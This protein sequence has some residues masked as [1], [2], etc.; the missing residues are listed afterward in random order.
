MYA[1][2]SNISKGKPVMIAE[3]GWPN[4]GDNSNKA[5]P[6]D[7]NA[8]KYFINANRWASANDIPIFYFSSFD[9][10]WK[11]HHEGDVGARWGLWDKDENLKF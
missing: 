2:V 9:E 11:V 10:S 3:T 6:S 4:C 5:V 7:Q 1:M 8:M